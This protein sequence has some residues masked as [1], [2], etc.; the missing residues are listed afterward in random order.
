MSFV[1]F[2]EVNEPFTECKY[3]RLGRL[4]QYRNSSGETEIP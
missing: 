2:V 1:L 3:E 4:Y